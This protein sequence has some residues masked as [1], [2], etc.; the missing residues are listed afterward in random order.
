MEFM[1][2]LPADLNP[3][4]IQTRFKWSSLLD[5]IIQILERFESWAK[6]DNS[7]IRNFLSVC[8]V[9]KILDFSNMVFDSFKFVAFESSLEN[10][11]KKAKRLI[12]FGPLGQSGKASNQARRPL[13]NCFH[14]PAV[15]RLGPSSRLLS[16]ACSTPAC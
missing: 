8:Q 10:I 7:S 13:A 2:F 5:F 12:G 9:W 16:I 15:K 3:V 4:K 14:R 11:V 6:K 1:R